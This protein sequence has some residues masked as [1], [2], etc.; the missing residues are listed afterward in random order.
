MLNENLRM[1]DEEEVVRIN[2]NTEVLTKKLSKSMV[3]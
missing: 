1:T 3:C 2:A